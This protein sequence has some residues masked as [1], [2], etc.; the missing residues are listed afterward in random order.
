MNY[1]SANLHLTMAMCFPGTVSSRVA[2]LNA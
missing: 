1:A 2:R